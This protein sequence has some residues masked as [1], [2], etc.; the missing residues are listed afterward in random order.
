MRVRRIICQL[1]S[2]RL[3]PYSPTLSHKRDDFREKKSYS[4]QNVCSDFLY[5]FETLLIL[6]RIE[7]KVMHDMYV[8]SNVTTIVFCHILLK[9]EFSRQIF[10]KILRYFRENPSFVSRVVPYGQTDV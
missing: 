1:W 2:V 5:N 10:R 4:T 3:Y 9:L 8:G 6:R 7:R